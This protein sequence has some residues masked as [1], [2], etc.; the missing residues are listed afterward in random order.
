MKHLAVEGKRQTAVKQ[1]PAPLAQGIL[2]AAKVGQAVGEKM[3]QQLATLASCDRPRQSAG[4]CLADGADPVA[5][6]HGINL[7]HLVGKGEGRRDGLA[8]RQFGAVLVI[9]IPA[10]AKGLAALIEQH[11]VLLSQGAVEELHPAVGVALPAIAGSEKM[12]ALHLGGRDG[13][14]R[15]PAFQL[16]GEAPLVWALPGESV[17]LMCF[18]LSL[19]Q[20]GQ[21]GPAGALI[22]GQVTDAVARLGECRCEGAH[23]GKEGQHLLTMVA[24]V[25]GLLTQLCHQIADCRIRGAKPAVS[26]VQ[27]IAKNKTQLHQ[28]GS[29][30]CWQLR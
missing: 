12:L 7:A 29:P 13:K 8:R 10:R 9:K 14:A 15:R 25:V 1:A 22:E 2:I 11:P 27:L 24:A 16:V 26:G 30:L 28:A 3:G 6:Q 21:I 18:E 5:G 23:G 19:Q 4:I 17:G 20:A